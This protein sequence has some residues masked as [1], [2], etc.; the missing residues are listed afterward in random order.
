MGHIGVE[1][2]GNELGCGFVGWLIEESM[3]LIFGLKTIL[4]LKDK[5]M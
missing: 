4:H 3:L 2:L 5:V 1:R